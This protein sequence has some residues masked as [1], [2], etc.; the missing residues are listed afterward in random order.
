M[1]RRRGASFGGLRFSN[2]LA[3]R[4]KSQERKGIPTSDHAISQYER[5]WFKA[6][7]LAGPFRTVG[8]PIGRAQRSRR[9]TEKVFSFSGTPTEWFQSSSQ[10]LTMT[11][12]ITYLRS[13]LTIY[14]TIYFYCIYSHMYLLS[15]V[16]I[17]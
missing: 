7:T 10:M 5:Q 3:I 13:I 17:E 16:F 14:F 1:R 11:D 12:V 6:G 2:E 8:Q 15:Y 4:A 9:G